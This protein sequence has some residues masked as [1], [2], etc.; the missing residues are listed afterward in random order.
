ML[1]LARD[2]CDLRSSAFADSATSRAKL[3]HLPE[4][5]DTARTVDVDLCL[6]RAHHGAGQ[7]TT[8]EASA[9]WADGLGDSRRAGG[10]A[11]R[12]TTGLRRPTRV[13]DT[14]RAAEVG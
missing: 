5:H 2:R 1:D 6:R 9:R 8:A 7:G 10:A 11:R 3:W 13:G 12:R 4:I 14:S